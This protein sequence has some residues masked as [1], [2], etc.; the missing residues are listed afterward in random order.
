M[1]TGF[2]FYYYTYSVNIPSLLSVHMTLSALGLLIG[3]MINPMITNIFTDAKKRY[4]YYY[5]MSAM[6]L[7]IASFL[8]SSPI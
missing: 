1:V 6:V 8:A 2:A 4:I 7:F 3:A 5:S